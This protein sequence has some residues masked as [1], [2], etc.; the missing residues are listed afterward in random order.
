MRWNGR[1]PLG[2]MGLGGLILSAHACASSTATNP[3]A[4][5]T[6]TATSVTVRGDASLRGDV[7]AGG[8][9]QSCSGTAPRCSE[10]WN[11][12]ECGFLIADAECLTGT[13]RCPGGTVFPNECCPRWPEPCRAPCVQDS[14]VSPVC[15][16]SQ[17]VCPD[18]M[19]QTS[20]P[21]PSAPVA[22]NGGTLVTLASGQSPTSLALDA[23]SIYWT[24]W[25]DG[26]DGTVME[27]SLTG[28]TPVALAA[29]LEFADGIAVDGSGVYFAGVM[30]DDGGASLFKVGLAGGTATRLASGFINYP[31]ALGPS[32][33]YGM[34]SGYTIVKVPLDGGTWTPVT[35]S[36][37]SSY[38]IAVDA[39]SVY[40]TTFSSPAT[41]GKAPLTGG[42]PVTLATTP[43]TGWG[44]AVDGTYAYFGTQSA[45]MKVPID[46]GTL[47]TLADSAG[48]GIA[49]DDND[50]YF[51]D[52][53]S[54][55]KKVS[56][57]GGPV[58]TLATNLIKPSAIAVDAT[59]VYWG[60]RGSD[61][62]VNG[63]VL[64]L[65]PK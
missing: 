64:K 23:T 24:N 22:S 45:V 54:M 1:L 5:S 25:T 56:K 35:Y 15:Q 40:W 4:T 65:T 30:N 44:I 26:Y 16:G 50:V 12:N 57:S 41:V 61:N 60:N 39:N 20:G 11:G 62:T 2:L 55:V 31:F 32:G 49:L 43:D 13:W 34:A 29:G 58:I 7:D 3:T 21:C 46:G 6:D 36:G 33:V 8:S 52:G 18:G 51:T 48:Q 63:S 9:V 17:W 47:A 14:V 38:G 37:S 10:V 53:S 27:V 42:Q 28:G 19:S 59:S